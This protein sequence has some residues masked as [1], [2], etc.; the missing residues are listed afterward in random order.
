MK[1]ELF[2]RRSFVSAASAAIFVPHLAMAGDERSNGRVRALVAE[3]AV[4]PETA[5]GEQ[6]LNL[7]PDLIAA[8]RAG[9]QIR[10]RVDYPDRRNLLHFRAFLAAP[11][12]PAPP[13]PEL[14][15]DDP[16]L[17]AHLLFEIRHTQMSAFPEMS[18]GLYGRVLTEIKPSPFFPGL[19]GRLVGVQLGYRQEGE[20][21]VSILTVSVGGDHVIV[22]REGRG[23]IEL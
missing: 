3:G 5:I 14:R 18:L 22:A 16:R 20:T 6:P 21:P 13:S 7:P 23:R 19:T 11:G 1:P 8:L 4:A 10:A 15:A 12:D 9:A 2:G 17:F